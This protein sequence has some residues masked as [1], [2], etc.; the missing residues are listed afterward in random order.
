MDFSMLSQET[1]RLMGSGTICAG[2][3]LMVIET[4]TQLQMLVGSNEDGSA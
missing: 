1:A 3:V 2:S 4:L